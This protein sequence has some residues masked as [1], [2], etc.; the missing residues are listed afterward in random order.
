MVPVPFLLLLLLLLLHVGRHY[1]PWWLQE[2][3]ASLLFVRDVPSLVVRNV[4]ASLP[5]YHLLPLL[6]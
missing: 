5:E 2:V 4:L 3:C 6:L 1:M